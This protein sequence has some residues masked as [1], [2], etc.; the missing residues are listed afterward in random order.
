MSAFQLP[1]EDFLSFRWKKAVDS[2]AGK[3]HKHSFA[4]P[5]IT[6]HQSLEPVSNIGFVRRGFSRDIKTHRK[7]GL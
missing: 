5:R 3:N 6:G 1:A 7:S 2:N 4:I